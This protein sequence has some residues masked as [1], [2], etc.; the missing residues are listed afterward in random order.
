VRL[1]ASDERCFLGISV[2]QFGLRSS[3]LASN[4]REGKCSTQPVHTG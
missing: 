4:N 1:H 3:F 2:I